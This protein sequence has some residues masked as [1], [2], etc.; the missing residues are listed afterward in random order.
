MAQDL[1][2]NDGQIEA[3]ADFIRAFDDAYSVSAACWIKP[4]DTERLKLFVAS[5]DIDG[6]NIF[7]AYGDL[8]KTLKPNEW[9]DP[10]QIK[11]VNTSDPIAR[12]AI[13]HRDARSA[14]I[15]MWFNGTYFGGMGIDGAYIYP[16][17]AAMKSTP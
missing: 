4:Q 8:F 11:L 16:N 5:D 1:L 9:L 3:G 13:K 7:D 2:V 15:P 6:H 17:V 12:D 14:N 10:L